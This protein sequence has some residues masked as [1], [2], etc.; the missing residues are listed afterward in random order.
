MSMNQNFLTCDLHRIASNQFRSSLAL[1]HI[2]SK[3][4]TKRLKLFKLAIPG[5]DILRPFAVAKLII[6]LVVCS[7]DPLLSQ[8]YGLTRPGPSHFSNSFPQFLTKLDGQAIIAFS[9]V[10]FPGISDCF[11]KVHNKVMHCNDFPNP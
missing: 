8:E 1:L 11:N 6:S 5:F 4:H 2:S 3:S 10:G 7:L 9:I